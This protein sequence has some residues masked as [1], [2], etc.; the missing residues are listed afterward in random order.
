M[1]IDL[2]TL[3]PGLVLGTLLATAVW[4]D[5]ATRR[6]PNL[7][8]LPGLFAGVALNLLLPPGAG[9]FQWPVGGIGGGAA[10]A[11]AGGGLLLLLP[12]YALG[13]L[14]AGDVKLLAMVGA[15]LGPQAIMAVALLSL[16]AGGVLS[17]VVAIW[18]GVLPQVLRNVYAMVFSTVLR[19]L[20]GAGAALDA[21]ARPSGRLAYAVAILSGTLIYAALL[22]TT[23]RE[24]LS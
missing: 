24:F 5:L 12:M 14:G 4:H 8:I 10:L 7:L 6:I 1:N 3:L 15:F 2:L 19:T 21:P 13:A 22:H 17:L 18:L 11:G 9:P 20:G 16:L 23:L